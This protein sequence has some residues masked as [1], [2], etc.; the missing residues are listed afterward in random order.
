MAEGVGFLYDTHV[1]TQEVSMCSTSTA[2]EQVRAFKLRGYAGLII[3][4][5]L[6]KG[7]TNGDASWPWET[8]V[9]FFISSYEAAKKE[10]DKCGLS[11]FLGWEYTSAR[12]SN[13]LDFLTYGL[14][15]QFLLTHPNILNV[16]VEEY[17]ALVRKNGGY[18]AQAHPYRGTTPVDYR[19]LDGVE[20]FNAA[21]GRKSR[22]NQQA[23]EF[24]QLHGLPMQAGSDSHN[25]NHP[26]RLCGIALE[27][28]AENINDII[29]AIRTRNVTIIRG[30]K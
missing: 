1:H 9:R 27:K 12:W 13:G 19:L 14:T 2:A 20:V 22:A 28:K 6:C 26:H 15:P 23:Y 30:E 10:G 3:T 24:A 4:D 8:Q 11:V 17:S 18:M 16:T 25:I 29:D 5:H 21:N 7:Y